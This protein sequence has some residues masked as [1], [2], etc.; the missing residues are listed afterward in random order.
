MGERARGCVGG[1][2]DLPERGKGLVCAGARLIQGPGVPGL[3]QNS[4]ETED[5]P[6]NGGYEVGKLA[7]RALS[8]PPPKST[9]HKRAARF[10]TEINSLVWR[11]DSGRGAAQAQ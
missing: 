10:L 1:D 7:H 8:H 5:V 9:K 2:R 11:G 3:L 6:Q 4:L